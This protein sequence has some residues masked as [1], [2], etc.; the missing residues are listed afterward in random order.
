MLD[1]IM[2]MMA[3]RRPL[4][5]TGFLTNVRP[6][7]PNCTTEYVLTVAVLGLSRVAAGPCADADNTLGVLE[8]EGGNAPTQR[9]ERR[10]LLLGP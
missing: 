7:T 1:Q 9:T 8:F 10:A 5:T 6:E 2:W 3:D 4:R